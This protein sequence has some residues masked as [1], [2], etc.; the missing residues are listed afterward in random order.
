MIV[1]TWTA[2]DIDPLLN[3][4]LVHES[5]VPVI[6]RFVRPYDAAP[7]PGGKPLYW[8]FL[9]MCGNLC[10]LRFPDSKGSHRTG[11]A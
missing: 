9:T 4:W 7:C 5:L 8:G 3:A 1:F 6:F 10:G 11:V 2:F